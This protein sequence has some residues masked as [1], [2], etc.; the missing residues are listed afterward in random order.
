MF[1]AG[2][3]ASV[4]KGNSNIFHSIPYY[5]T[6]LFAAQ[7]DNTTTPKQHQNN[8]KHRATERATARQSAG[9]HHIQMLHEQDC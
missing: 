9:N 6:V 2:V 4:T 1:C 8:T 7:Q 5:Q 3:G